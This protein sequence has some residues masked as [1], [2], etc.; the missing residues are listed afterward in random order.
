MEKY[1]NLSPKNLIVIKNIAGAFFVKGASLVVSIFLLPAYLRFFN[2]Q[3]ILGVWFAILSVLQWVTLFDLGLGYG[4][5][6]K[7]PAAIE[8]QN[9]KKI[10]EY[11]STTYIFM[12]SLSI[13]VIIIG[14]VVIPWVNWAEIFNIDSSI[15]E[16]A[17]LADCVRIV[18]VGIIIQIVLKIIASILYAIQQSVV[19]NI[20]GLLSNIVVL[21]M[22]IFFPSRDT[23][24]NLKR[25]SIINVCAINIPYIICT[26]TVFCRKRFFAPSFSSFRLKYV[27]EIFNIGISLLWLQ[28][29][30]MMIS[31]MNEFL[32]SSFTKPEY[33]VEYQAYYKIFKTSAMIISLAL[34]P[35][36]SAVTAAQA[37]GDYIWIKKIYKLF[38]LGS[39]IC[40]AIEVCIIPFLQW[41]MNIWLGHDIVTVSQGYAF[42]FALSSGM[43]ILHSVNTAIGNGLSYFK[44]QMICMTV[45]AILFIPLAY[46]LVKITGSWIGIVIANTISLLPYQVLAPIFTMKLLGRKI[47]NKS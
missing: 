32:I 16:N 34:T 2:N 44:P 37:R 31:S 24:S 9:M 1:K 39:L 20:I 3:I 42:A 35:I 10:K 14:I 27:K 18:F 6:N 19:V 15:V 33:V 21:V 13:V 30:F 8:T 12:T 41:I 7:L 5:R 46:I 4:L 40:F 25:M 11:I 23:A 38:L 17:I 29:V 47:N 26:V 28:L 45:A 43:I 22:L 36:W